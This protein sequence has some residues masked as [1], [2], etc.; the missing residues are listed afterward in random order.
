LVTWMFKEKYYSNENFLKFELGQKPTYAWRSIWQ[1]KD[2]PKAGLVWL[3]E[4]ESIKIWK[5]KW[6]PS[7]PLF[8][9]Q[10][11]LLRLNR[12]AR[13]KGLIDKDIRG[14][15]MQLVMEIFTADEAEKICTL[16]ISPNKQVDKLIWS[17]TSNENFSVKSAYHMGAS[18]NLTNYDLY[19]L[20][21]LN[22][23]L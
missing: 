12:E 10:L 21:V 20:Q 19:R 18:K 1:A 17:G 23:D 6:I 11:P 13:F 15:N 8:A 7:P 16:P 3:V 2:L 14:W 4:N 9:V 5:D 22:L